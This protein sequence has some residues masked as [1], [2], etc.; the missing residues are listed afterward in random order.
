M[1]KAQKKKA[2]EFVQTLY[3]AHEHIRRMMDNNDTALAMDLLEQ[4]QQGAI[5]LGDLIEQAEGEG[6]ITI[7]FLEEYCELIYHIHKGIGNNKNELIR[8]I[9]KTLRRKLIQIE[10]SIKNDIKQ[11]LEVVFL[12]YN[13]SMWDSLES[14]WK[15]AESDENSDAYVIPIPYYDRNPDGSFRKEHWE[16]NLFPDYVPITKYDAYDFEERHP[17]IIFI[18]NPYDDCNSVTSVHPF[19]YSENLKQF[20]DNLVYIP[21]F[22]LD[23]ISPNN[24]QAIEGMEHFCTVPGVINADNIIVQSETMRLIYISVLTKA[25]GEDTRNYWENKILG[26]GSPKID[27]VLNTKREDMLISEDWKNIMQK[28]DG[29]WKKIVLYNTSIGALLQYNSKFLEKI[30]DVFRIF[31]ENKNEVALLW[32]PHPLIK[33]TIESMRPQLWNE[34]QEL[35]GQ[36]QEEGWGIYDDSMDIDR[37]VVI[38]DAYYGDESSVARLFS[39]VDGTVMIQ[40]VEGENILYSDCSITE[41]NLYFYLLSTKALMK[42]N[43]FTREVSFVSG[44]NIE[45]YGISNIDTMISD[46]ENLFMLDISGKYL[47]KCILKTNQYEYIDISCNKDEYWNFAALAKYENKIFVFPRLADAVVV[48]EVN[49]Q[50]VYRQTALY[51]DIKSIYN[52]PPFFSCGI[53][54][55]NEMWLINERGKIIVKYMLDSEEYKI[56]YLPNFIERCINATL[57]GTTI[58]LLGALGKI[59]LWKI[60]ASDVEEIVN[61]KSADAEYARI[62]VVNETAFILPHFGKNILKLNTKTKDIQVFDDYPKDFKYQLPTNWAKYWNYCEDIYYIYFAMQSANYMLCVN[63]RNECIEWRKITLPTDEEQIE[64][65]KTNYKM[66]DEKGI[67]LAGYLAWLVRERHSINIL[68]TSDVGENIWKRIQ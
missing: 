60:G 57:S 44:L 67:S 62:I 29:S 56:Y 33:A 18:H 26:L 12:P 42:Y 27:K 3:Q 9:Y 39:K 49:S 14:I 7:G 24:Q 2:L 51:Q 66:L 55:K 36:Y 28:S 31:K 50:N 23:E 20:T 61:L 45:Y 15:A 11:Q 16:G 58:Y 48:I 37:A 40:S 6:F 19:F 30:K 59:Y 22:I 21:Y 25:A 4:C 52:T 64:Y 5:K 13:A 46:N 10:N 35:V 65:C 53:H 17:D 68:A 43:L 54:N 63:K 34:Y 8:K 32:R 1:K 41:N 47:I 38:S